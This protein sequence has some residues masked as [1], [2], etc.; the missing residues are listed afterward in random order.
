MNREEILYLIPYLISLALSAGIFIYAWMHRQVRGAGAY[1]WFMGG[2]TASNFGFIMKLITFNLELK[3]FWDKFLWVVQGTVIIVAFLVFAIQ[4]TEHKLKHPTR[5][6][7]IV[8]VMPILFNLLVITDNLHHL[9]YPNPSLTPGYP[10]PNLNYNFTIVVYLFALYIYATTFFG[11]SLLLR[12]A[13][14]SNNLYRAQFIIVTAGFLI[15][16]LLSMFSLFNIYISPQRDISPFSLAVG[17]LIVAWGLFRYRVF[18]LVPIARDTIFENINDPIM[19]LDVQDRIVDINPA[20]LAAL[21]LAASQVIGKPGKTIFAP[22][23]DLVERFS[24]T[25]EGR[26][27]IAMSRDDQ[28]RNYELNISPLRD[29]RGKLIG[30]LFIAKD[31]TDRFFLEQS[32]LHVNEKLEQRVFERTQELATAYDTT[33]EGWAKALELRDKETEGHSRR[34]T[35]LT[36]KLARDLDVSEDDLIQIH[37]GAILHDIGKMAVPDEILRKADKLNDKEWEIVRRHPII[38]YEL[39]SPIP[40][41]KKALDIPYCHHEKWDGTGYPRG[42]KGEQ[43][44]LAARIFAV[45]DVWDAVQSDRPY[46]ERWPRERAI[47]YLIEQSGHHFDPSI[48]TV[49]LKL[50]EQDKIYLG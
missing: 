9:I 18:D 10:F 32:L 43:I 20:A 45:A 3:I 8:F 28:T 39:L 31:I 37:R 19:V 35:E 27:D 12:R 48:I 38:A 17:N 15:P 1:T 14:Q 36:M 40:Y 30:R 4:Y 16:I 26:A 23:P 13:F 24:N 49:F 33:L 25:N 5:F 2:Q 50:I 7:F 47:Q 41:L 29:H 21:K 22:W 11:I 46:K 44:P 6:W 34:V 42:L